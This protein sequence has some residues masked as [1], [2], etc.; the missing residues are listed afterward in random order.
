[1]LVMMNF[2]FRIFDSG[3]K[4]NN[5]AEISSN[6]N[7]AVQKIFV[8]VQSA[9]SVDVSGSVFDNDVGRLDLNMPSGFGGDQVFWL[10]DGS[11]IFSEAGGDGIELTSEA[12][13]CVKL[14][15][16]RVTYNKSPDQILIEGSCVSKTVGDVGDADVL[17]FSTA[18]TLRK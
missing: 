7:F 2:S 18:I 8:A 10:E 14:R 5:V 12:V 13:D 6:V 9:D 15:F 16:G 1:M 3:V 11:V 4:S 17:N